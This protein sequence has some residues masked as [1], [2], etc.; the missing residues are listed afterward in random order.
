MHKKLADRGV[1]LALTQV[2]LSLLS[3]GAMQQEL[4]ATAQ[5][6]GVTVIAY[7]PLGLGMLTGRYSVDGEGGVPAGPRGG[8]FRNILP[9]CRTVLGTL[10]EI[11]E[12]R[13]VS[14]SQV[15]ARCAAPC[16]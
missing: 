13:G 15:C 7:S 12:A 11:A 4:L 16:G 5:E 2:Q 3:W 9:S 6:L 10:Q 8:L 1:K 14:Q